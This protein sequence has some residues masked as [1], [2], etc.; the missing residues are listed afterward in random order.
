[1]VPDFV[2]VLSFCRMTLNLALNVSCEEWT[3]SA[4]RSD[5]FELISH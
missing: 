3:V 4:E 2:F 1:M 5:L